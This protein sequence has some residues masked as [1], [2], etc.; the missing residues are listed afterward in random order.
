MSSSPLADGIEPQALAERPGCRSSH[1]RARAG[2][3]GGADRPRPHRASG[4]RRARATCWPPPTWCCR[5]RG[6]PPSRRWDRASRSSPSPGQTDRMKR[7]LEE[8]RLFGEAR[9][10]V[11][12]IPPTSPASASALL[13]RPRRTSAGSAPSAASA[14]ADPGRSRRSSRAARLAFPVA[15][16]KARSSARSSIR[17]EPGSLG[18]VAHRSSVIAHHSAAKTMVPKG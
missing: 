13:S 18:L 3:R 6:P 10:L 11:D 12:R 5:R 2:G 17:L 7:F 8:N 4:A 9:L 1:P 15:L 16:A 14:S